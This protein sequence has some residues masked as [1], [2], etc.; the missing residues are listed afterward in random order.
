MK[1]RQ[2]E[3]QPK[4]PSID[5]WVNKMHCIYT[6]D[7]YLAIKMNEMLIHIITWTNLKGILSERSPIQCHIVYDYTCIKYPEYANV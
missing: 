3:K 6:I 2:K 7:H 5:E 1:Q 4:Y